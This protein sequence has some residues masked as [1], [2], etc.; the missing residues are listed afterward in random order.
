MK[1]SNGKRNIVITAII[2]TFI[3]FFNQIP[4][5][6][7]VT[8][9]L[10]N[11]IA[12]ILGHVDDTL[13]T[14]FEQSTTNGKLNQMKKVVDTLDTSMDQMISPYVG[15]LTLWVDSNSGTYAGQTVTVTNAKGQN[16]TGQFVAR[17][18][19]YEV[20]FP[21][22]LK[23]S[24]TIA[25]PYVASSKILNLTTSVTLNGSAKRQQ[26][27]GDLQQMTMADIQAAC[28]AG[29]INQLASVGD[30]FSG[31][32]NYTYTIIGI[33]QDKP[34]DTNGNLLPSN[35]YGNVLTVMPLGA[36]A[37]KGNNQ[38]VATNAYATPYATSHGSP[39]ERIN[40]S[41]I[42]NAGWASSH[43][44]SVIMASCYNKL[45]E[46]TKNV[47][48]SVQKI[49]GTYFDGNQTTGDKVFLLSG[50]EVFGGYGYGSGSYCFSTEASATFQYQYFSNIA[51]SID[52]RKNITNVNIWWLR[53]PSC[54]GNPRFC[55]VLN[56]ESGVGNEGMEYGVLPA[57]CIY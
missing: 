11:S 53:S 49:T 36:P 1:K 24:Y 28:K 15:S 41:D 40:V 55:Y 10:Q 56:G 37:G 48:G 6:A 2:L 25:Y 33:D 42:S 13:G 19:H 3:I 20:D 17:N 47:I 14:S 51:T 43:M 4:A 8:D 39:T 21:S 29:V 52:S 31:G 7:D 44:R 26:L 9:N 38:P 45:P 12:I 23:G 35:S 46:A 32:T 50:K 54:D 16:Q 57:F 27:F 22:L 30:T 18:G 5:N 34:S